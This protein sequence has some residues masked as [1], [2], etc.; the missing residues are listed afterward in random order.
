MVRALFRD[1]LERVHLKW[2]QFCISSGAPIRQEGDAA[3]SGATGKSLDEPGGRRSETRRA[4]RIYPNLFA[5]HL[6]RGTA[7]HF[8]G[9]LDLVTNPLRQ[10][11]SIW[12]EHALALGNRSERDRDNARVI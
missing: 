8:D 6:V 11:G 3:R 10:N 1:S 12:D 7:T 5:S 9:P 4:G 2:N